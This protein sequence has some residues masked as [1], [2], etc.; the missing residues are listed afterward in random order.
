MQKVIYVPPWDIL[1]GEDNVALRLAEPFIL[2]TISGTSGTDV[3]VQSETIP[4]MDGVYVE[5]VRTE[6]AEITCEIN[7]KGSSRE[8]MYRQRFRLIRALTPKAEPGTLY[9]S[10]D[11]ITLKT[12]AIPQSSP[13]FTGRIKN[14]NAAEVKF[15]CPVPCWEAVEETN[16]Y[17]AWLGG[18]FEFPIAIDDEEGMEFGVI[19]NGAVVRLNSVINAALLITID[20]PA[21]S[22]IIISNA[23]TGESITLEKSLGDSERLIINTKR[24]GKSVVLVHADGTEEDAFNYI[25][26]DSVLFELVPGENELVYENW[27][28]NEPTTCSVAFHEIYSGV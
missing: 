4:G 14:Y 17:V 11:Y 10:N 9:Y 6:S 8:E 3:T 22:P 7:V 15:F 24:G 1:G 12:G 26:P 19:Q 27:N 25:T 21:T 2:G 13:K 16:R 5:N 23:T 18:A 28:Q 20:A